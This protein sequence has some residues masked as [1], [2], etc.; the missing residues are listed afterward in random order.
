MTDTGTAITR[1]PP[2]LAD[3]PAGDFL[4]VDGAGTP[5]DESFTSAISA[6]FATRAALGAAADVPLE[7]T[8]TQDGDP[9]R[10]ELHNP[11]G[12]RWQLVVPAPD[13]VTADAVTAVGVDRR[14]RLVRRPAQRVA[15]LVHHGPYSDEQ[16]SLDALY[17][18]VAASGLTPGGPHT[19]VYVTDPST[20]APAGLRTVLQVPVC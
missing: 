11:H 19:E 10:F 14:V 9:L 13:G 18:F 6:L 7:G 4:V 5:E 17:A 1:T 20:T 8:Y 15:R 16:P 12:W 3:L 2:E